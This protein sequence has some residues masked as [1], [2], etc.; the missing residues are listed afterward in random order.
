MHTHP[1][2][3]RG[4]L[5]LT[6]AAAAPRLAGWGTG[7]GGSE[8]IPFLRFFVHSL[9]VSPGAVAAALVSVVPP[10]LPALTIRRPLVRGLSFGAV[11][12]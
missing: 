3:R 8:G 1:H 5:A 7:C 11:K 6:A 9:V 2:D 10:L 12:S 4:F